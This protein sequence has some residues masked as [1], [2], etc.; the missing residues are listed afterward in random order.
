LLENELEKATTVKQRL[1]EIYDK[2][3]HLERQLRLK[4]NSIEPK[5]ECDDSSLARDF[6]RY[7]CSDVKRYGLQQPEPLTRYEGEL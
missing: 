5:S 7:K 3:D 1:D 6:Y 4:E 2:I